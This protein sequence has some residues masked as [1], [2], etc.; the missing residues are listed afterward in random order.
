MN[1]HTPP[2]HATQALARAHQHWQE[3]QS[4]DATPR[5]Y[6]I[7]LSR[8]AGTHGTAIAREVADR[9]H[10]PIYDSELLQ[11]IADEMGVRRSLV[12]SVDERRVDW[13][14]ETMSALFNVPRV[15]DAAFFR[16]LLQTLFSLAAHGNCVIVGR[17]AAV[18]LPLAS[19]LRVRVVAP[20]E[21]RI[22]VIRH[23]QRLPHKEAAA[24][25][26]ATD[27]RRDQFLSSHFRIDPSDPANYDL[28]VNVARYNQEQC[29][30]LIIAAY[31]RLRSQTRSQVLPATGVA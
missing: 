25:V 2:E 18:A 16:Q 30:D 31:D 6:T 14:N 27:R 22:D 4:D 7:A 11:R 10:W 1:F 13:V 3:R 28:I 29:A 20:L 21:H 24:Q 5:Q 17:G 19:T 15:T 9:L 12:E 23:E 8:L 26:D